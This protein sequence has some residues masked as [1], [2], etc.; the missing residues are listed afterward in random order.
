MTG[1]VV[2]VGIHKIRLSRRSVLTRRISRGGRLRFNA[3]LDEFVQ[4]STVKPDAATLGTII[5]FDATPFRHE[6][7]N[8]IAVRTFHINSFQGY[9]T[10]LFAMTFHK[11][12]MTSERR[13]VKTCYIGYISE[14]RTISLSYTHSRLTS[15][16]PSSVRTISSM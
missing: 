6:Q 1:A 3:Q 5:N 16:R 2:E 14:L 12:K 13:F 10:R 9:E 8:V 7:R 4:L 15:L 11:K